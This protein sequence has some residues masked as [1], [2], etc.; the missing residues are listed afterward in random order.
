MSYDLFSALISGYVLLFSTYKLYNSSVK[1]I[2]KYF[3]LFD[4]VVNWIIFLT[5]FPEHCYFIE[6][7]LIFVCISM[8][9]C[10]TALLN[11]FISSNRVCVCVCVCILLLLLFWY[12][13]TFL[14][15]C[16]INLGK[17]KQIFL[18]HY[19]WSV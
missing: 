15:G 7:Q 8:Y 10:T 1:F 2:L 5:L 6:I 16:Y 12:S 14:K 18:L 13:E 4:A 11:L 3:M 19:I 17:Q 9:L